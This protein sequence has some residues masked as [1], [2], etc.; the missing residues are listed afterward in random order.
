[1]GVVQTRNF[2]WPMRREKRLDA[3]KI[4]R[5][6]RKPLAP[7][8]A[9]AVGRGSLAWS[10][11]FSTKILL[12]LYCKYANCCGFFRRPLISPSHTASALAMKDKRL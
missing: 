8:A 4:L 3:S 2:P 12:K 6:S 10:P 1:M 11:G 9:R 5:N 7:Y